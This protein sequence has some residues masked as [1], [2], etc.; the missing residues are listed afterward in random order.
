MTLIYNHF[1]MKNQTRVKILADMYIHGITL[2]TKPNFYQ[3]C[4]TANNAFDSKLYVRKK[5]VKKGDVLKTEIVHS[6]VPC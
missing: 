1:E 4:S 3:F 5:C 2:R 6:T